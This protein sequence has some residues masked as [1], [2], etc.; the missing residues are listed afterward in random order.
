MNHNRNRP[1]NYRAWV[2]GRIEERA[3]A[4][5]RYPG[6]AWKNGLKG[7]VLTSVTVKADGTIV[8]MRVQEASGDVELD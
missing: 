6:Q 7:R 5:L 8:D 2:A 4:L 3:K 1:L